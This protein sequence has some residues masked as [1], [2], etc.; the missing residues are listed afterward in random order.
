MTLSVIPQRCSNFAIWLQVSVLVVASV[1]A[2][3]TESVFLDL[4]YAFDTFPCSLS[5]NYVTVFRKYF[6][7]RQAS[8]RGFG[9]FSFQYY[10]MKSWCPSWLY[11]TDITI[12]INFVCIS[13][14]NC[15]LVLFAGYLKFFHNTRNV[16]EFKLLQF[17][18]DAVQNWGWTK[19]RM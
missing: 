3:C 12:D 4:T 19:N 1:T 18:L 8:C 13:V 9:I 17:H 10:N 11:L 5:F 6:T 14:C 2:D 7:H 15:S 16:E